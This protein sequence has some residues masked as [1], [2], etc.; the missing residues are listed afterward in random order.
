V[1]TAQ[2]NLIEIFSR[3]NKDYFVVNT[4]YDYLWLGN[5]HITELPADVFGKIRFKQIKIFHQCKNLKRIHFHA[6]RSS[7]HSAK[8]VYIWAENVQHHSI[9]SDYSLLKVINSFTNPSLIELHSNLGVLREND[10]GAHLN[11]IEELVLFVSA[12]EGRPFS[13]MS[14]LMRLTLFQTNLNHIGKHSLEVASNPALNHEPLYITL[15]RSRLNDDSFEID[16]L[17]NINKVSKRKEVWLDLSENK[18][19][20]LKEDVFLPFLME[21]RNNINLYNNPLNCEDCR[22][23]WLCKNNQIGVGRVHNENCKEGFYK[24]GVTAALS[25]TDCETRYKKCR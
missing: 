6:M 10:L 7:W 17:S 13:R 12:I 1:N 15:S 11:H 3:I 18:I 20:Y 14:H 4:E 9:D 8:E 2:L 21:S 16:S 25:P 19:T 5:E 23:A 24:N 22:S